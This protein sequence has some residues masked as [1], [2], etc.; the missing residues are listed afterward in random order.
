MRTIVALGWVAL[1]SST[2]WATPGDCV[3]P[4]G[5]DPARVTAQMERSDALGEDLCVLVA[6]PSAGAEAKLT[7]IVL[8]GLG[9]GPDQWFLSGG[10]LERVDALT[11]EGAL[12]PTAIVAPEGRGGYWTDWSDGRHP[13]GRWVHEDLVNLLKSRYGLPARPE[14]VALAGLSMGGFGALSLGLR[15][16]DR[17]GILVGL[18]PTDMELATQAQPKRKTYTN[19]F[20]RPLDKRRVRALNPK[21]LVAG[22]GGEG[23]L[24]LLAWG[25]AE[26]AK[27]SKGSSRLRAGLEKGGVR[28]AF[29]VVKGGKH[30]F[31]TTWSAET[32]TWLLREIG[33]HVA[34]S[35]R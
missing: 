5:L 18:S 31:S 29:R 2:A 6:K 14:R 1:F 30:G 23:Q 4:E 28:S 32:M 35:T 34:A 21:R 16:P 11:A 3:V 27:F 15:H 26:P 19:V 33:R 25:S 7:L 24:V 9:A 10:I 13:W 8:H 20:G 17:F 12:P 22:G